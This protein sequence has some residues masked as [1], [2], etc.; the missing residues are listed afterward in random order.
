MLLVAALARSSRSLSIALHQ[1]FNEKKYFLLAA[2]VQ[3]FRT[4]INATMD[5]C[6]M[7]DNETFSG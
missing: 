7:S 2:L 5:T 6:S 3:N 4:S 1:F